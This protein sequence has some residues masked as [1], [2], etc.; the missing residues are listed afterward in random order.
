MSGLAAL[1]RIV[2]LH[3]FSLIPKDEDER[4]LL[5]LEARTYRYRG[6]GTP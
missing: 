5:K 1:S 3:D 6:E 2:T 4:L